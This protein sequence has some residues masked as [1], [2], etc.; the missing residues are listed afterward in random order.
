MWKKDLLR[1]NIHS[2]IKN[3]ERERHYLNL[4][5]SIFKQKPTANRIV[6]DENS[7]VFPFKSE[8]SQGCPTTTSF[9][10]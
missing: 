7:E 2:D 6:N 3:K 9:Q 8:T 5:N 1:F 10:H 4:I